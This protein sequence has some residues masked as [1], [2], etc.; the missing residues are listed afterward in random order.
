MG[1]LCVFLLFLYIFFHERHM[2]SPD[3]GMYSGTT[4]EAAAWATHIWPP[5]WESLWVLSASLPIQLP[6]SAPEKEVGNGS[7]ACIPA[8][9]V[10]D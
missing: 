3:W 7:C 5:I 1:F 8:T 2:E 4:H 6:A 10:G 9:H